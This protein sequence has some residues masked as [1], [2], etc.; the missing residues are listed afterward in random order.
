MSVI[1]MAT[2]LSDQR[3]LEAKLI[4]QICRAKIKET[5]NLAFLAEEVCGGDMESRAKLCARFSSP[6][7]VKDFIA[8][9]EAEQDGAGKGVAFDVLNVRETPEL[10]AVSVLF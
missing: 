1:L 3:S 4:K 2:F 5:A 7:E 9:F 6:V 8:E 10:D